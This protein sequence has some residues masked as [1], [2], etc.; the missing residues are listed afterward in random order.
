MLENI[1]NDNDQTW[2]I[3]GSIPVD[4][5]KDCFSL[6]IIEDTAQNMP[7]NNTMQLGIIYLK[8]NGE[9]IWHY[10]IKILDHNLQEMVIDGDMQLNPSEEPNQDWQDSW[11]RA[12][13]LVFHQSG[14]IINNAKELGD[15]EKIVLLIKQDI[16]PKTIPFDVMQGYELFI[17]TPDIVEK[18]IDKESTSSAMQEQT[19]YMYQF[20]NDSKFYYAYIN[21]ELN[22]IT[23]GGPIDSFDYY[24]GFSS[25]FNKLLACATNDYY[26]ARSM[27]YLINELVKQEIQKQYIAKQ[28]EEEKI[29]D[30]ELT[31]LYYL[32]LMPD[33]LTMPNIHTIYLKPQYE[34]CVLAS[35]NVSGLE[36]GKIYLNPHF[37]QGTL[38]YVVCDYEG[39]NHKGSLLLSDLG[40]DK[41]QTIDENSLL[42]RSTDILSLISIKLNEQGQQDLSVSL[43][44]FKYA[45]VDLSNQLEP[46]KKGELDNSEIDQESL[47]RLLRLSKNV[48]NLEKQIKALEQKLSLPVYVNFVSYKQALV[49]S[50]VQQHNLI[51]A[52]QFGKKIDYVIKL[53]QPNQTVFEKGAIY[54]EAKADGVYCT[55]IGNDNN[56]QIGKLYGYR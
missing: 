24:S 51:S 17:T 46:L 16:L 49:K 14:E 11:Q 4:P 3:G 10:K 42:A 45:V 27:L 50:V 37:A 15:T 40:I 35:T 34:L 53:K 2:R 41:Q 31:N 7:E 55:V 30:V 38:E 19:I 21:P 5:V 26:N 9:G 47:Q 1:N 22:T 48:K 20:S 52:D 54:L 12:S 18:W 25:N 43:N 56:P 29:S 39:Y 6:Q 33:D 23:Q 44:K 32:E 13:N 8:D 36:Q 28:A